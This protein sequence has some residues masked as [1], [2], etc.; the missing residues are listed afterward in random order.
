LLAALLAASAASAQVGTGFPPFSSF[1]GGSFESVNNANLNVHLSI[2]VLSK[3]G[4]G[5]PYSYV[6]NYD[7]SVWSP[8]SPAGGYVWTPL[9][10]W[11]T[12]PQAETGR[13]GYSASQLCCPGQKCG[14]GGGSYYNQ[15]T[16]WQYYDT[17]G[18]AHAFPR[19]LTVNDSSISCPNGTGNWSAAGTSTDELYTMSVDATP[20]ATTAEDIDGHTFNMQT[21]TVTDSNGNQISGGTDTLG[22]TALSIT[23]TGS[24]TNPPIITTYAYTN[25]G[26][27]P[28]SVKTKIQPYT[29]QTNFGCS[30][31]SEYGPTTLGLVSEIDL[32]DNTKYTFTYE[33]TP[34]HSPNV[35][36]RL[37]EVTLPTGGYI[38][39]SY[40]AG[41]NGITCSDGSTATLTRTLYDNE[42][43]SSAWTYAHTESGSAW[44]SDVTAPADPQGN[45]AYTTISFQG[46]YETERNVYSKNGGTLLE[47]VDTC[48]NGA[49][50]PC[51]GTAVSLPITNRTVQVTLPSLAPSKTY[52]TY[53]SYSLPTETDQYDYGPTLVGKTLTSYA[54]L[55]NYIYDRP[56]SITVENAGGTTVSQTSISYDQ[57]AVTTTNGTPQHVAVSGSR[58]NPT[59]VS[60]TGQNM[61]TLTRSYTYY[62]T[63][64]VQVATDVN[65]AQTQFTYG[66]CGNSFPTTVTP[67]AGPAVQFTYDPNCYAGVVLTVNTGNGTTTY[68]YND[69][70]SRVTS[71]TDPTQATT[72]YYYSATTAET[73][74]DFATNST[75]D[76]LTTVD[77][78]GRLRF[79]QRRQSQSS[80]TFDSVETTYDSL[81]RPY[82]TSPP[83]TASAGTA[84]SGSTWNTFGY[85]ALARPTAVTDA[86]GG[87]VTFSYPE[88]DM[89]RTINAPAGENPKKAQYEYD[90]LGRL[91]SVCEITS[92]SGSGACSQNTSAT[93][94]FTSYG[95]DALRDLTSVSQ[96]GQS[97]AYQYDGMRRLISETNPE[98]GTTTYTYDSDS[99]CGTY[100]GDLVKKVDAVGDVTCF[101]YDAGH[102]LTSA[103]YPSGTYASLTP[104]KHFVYDAATVNGVAMS[105]TAGRLAEAYTCSGACTSKLTDLG[106][107]YSARGEVTDVYEFTPNSGGYYHA[108]AT[109]WANGLLYP[110]NLKNGAGTVSFIPQITYSPDGEGRVSYVTAA[111]GQNP[112]PSNTPV[113]YN[114]FGEPTAV[115]FGSL[116][117]DAFG[118]DSNTGRMTQYGFAVN[119][120]S[121]V[122]NLTWNTNGTLG[123]LGITDPFDASDTQ[124]CAYSYDDL[125]RISN[126]DCVNSQNQHIWTQAFTFDAFGN[127]KKTGNNGGTSFLPNYSASTN[128]MTSL[129]GLT[130][131][132]DANGNLTYDTYHTYSWDSAGKAVTLGSTGL[133]YDALGRM[134]EQNRSGS[135][136]QIVYAPSGWKLALMNGQT[137]SKAFVPLP[138]NDKAVYTSGPTLSYY[139]HAD[140][141]GSSRLDSTPSRT[142]SF[143]M[144][145]GPY[146]EPYAGS[147]TTDLS[148]TGDNPDTVSDEYDFLYR[149][150]HYIQGRWISPDPAG[151]AVVDPT[152]PQ[153]WDRYAYVLNSPLVFIDPLGLLGLDSCSYVEQPD[154]GLPIWVCIGDGGGAF[155]PSGGGPCVEI[156][157]AGGFGYDAV[158]GTTPPIGPGGSPPRPPTKP[159]NNTPRQPCTGFGFALTGGGVGA[160]GLIGTGAAATGS[161]GAGVFYGTGSGLS[162]GAFSSGGMVAY[163]GSHTAGAPAQPNDLDSR[164]VG[165]GFGGVGVGVTFTNAGSAQALTSTTTTWSFDIAFSFGA[166][167]QV[168][169]GGGITAVSI[170]WG[171]GY[172][173]SFTQMNTA[174]AATGGGCD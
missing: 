71:V 23:S 160:A 27:Q 21:G 127:L 156:V 28:E 42:G 157:M 163:F 117:S 174:T 96:S 118:Y 147:G 35:T 70:F 151:I 173:L 106:F 73:V 30:G 148:F 76:A 45:Q 34:G 74:L 79:S 140:W 85:D 143:D 12:Q 155:P 162:A 152:T 99:T 66:A 14:V 137:L 54:S 84:Y 5:M 8:V 138:A 9:A 111:S 24:L 61:G 169:S 89:L 44:T 49:S 126:A 100:S 11:A 78:L 81:G 46:I 86:G 130:P 15:Y 58:G 1:S 114:S 166:S 51:T 69:P 144:A 133:T 145:Y 43:N 22:T 19:S 87:Q 97:R 20:E 101:A 105:N 3:P 65:N 67:P 82:E 93:G 136:T 64:N 80:S 39:Y 10:G 16:N 95:Y 17:S 47:T 77:G 2:P 37:A 13:Y 32:P 115:D 122:G 149:E 98:S 92:A 150:Y 59:T 171:P 107:S 120:S 50:I 62:D 168:S 104:A 57:T 121:V 172:G 113:S 146:G 55:G 41:S 6:L 125:A 141:L 154:P 88:N 116:D 83:Y 31:V 161:A 40:S 119:G 90:G 139:R 167:I 134:V 123:Q 29:V 60:M 165:G 7:S 48:Y 135:Y 38:T 109:Y 33:T 72:N 128:Q 75:V 132:Y 26:G 25:A 159:P 170:T 91:T 52:T 153:S 158:C 129:G 4:R 63:G 102:R 112:I 53:N 142:V 124:T 68:S 36:A 108:S 18:T 94:Y 56:S 131:T 103:T 164:A 110:L